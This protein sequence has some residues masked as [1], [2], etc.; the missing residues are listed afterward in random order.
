M[1]G[2]IIAI[3]IAGMI[4]NVYIPIAP[5]LLGAMVDYQGIDSDVAGRLIS[6]NF[7]GA[8]VSTVLAI[9]IL[10]RPGWN[11][12]LTMLFSLA[13]VTITS[14]AAVWAANDIS[15]LA[16]IRF[17]NGFGAGLGFTV[18]AVA[19]VGSPNVE[20]AYAFL[21]GNPYLIG[22]L[23]L[24]L[25]PHVYSTVGIEGA[26]LGMGALNLAAFALVPY[27]PKALV[28]HQDGTH[29]PLLNVVGRGGRQRL[30]LG[31][32]LLV[33]FFLHYVFNSGI[34]TYFERIGVSFGM[35]ALESG[36][37]LG[38]SMA[39]GLLGMFLASMLGNRYSAFWMMFVG[40]VAI[41]LS[42]LYLLLQPTGVAFGLSTALFS[43]SI[44][45]VTPYFVAELSRIVP[46]GLG[47]LA[48]NIV[49]ITGFST[50]PFL[51]SLLVRD[52]DFIPSVALT[53]VGFV[54]VL[55]L[56]LLFAGLSR[57]QPPA[58]AATSAP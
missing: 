13:L 2:H 31:A 17:I 12:R 26:L 54:V 21:Y 37:I 34:W 14:P 9:F 53:A 35:S 52:N 48:A 39:A 15:L 16:I 42:T 23:G 41:L 6:Y 29:D 3:V 30:V 22:G 24:A 51:V 44:P 56:L 32:L 8:T 28:P 18:A 20:R 25:L 45:F 58:V 10:P 46:R 47:V 19:V 40:T 33:T 5:S 27:F 36:S 49:T 50:G 55:L 57:R 7:W 38:P 43:A 1:P 11:I 4:V